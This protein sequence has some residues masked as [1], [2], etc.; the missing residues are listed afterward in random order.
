M[1]PLLLNAARAFAMVAFAD[2]KLAPAE[3]QRFAHLASRDTTL[4]LAGHAE[5]TD[6]WT[7]AAKEVHEAES[8]GAALVTIRSEITA[9]ADKVVLMRVAQTA[10]VA[11]GKVELQENKA[12]A[13]LAEALGLDP[14]NY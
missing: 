12:I 7:Q 4:G 14:E 5:I 2:G 8:F 11:D 3:A 1:T 6:A 10:I 9:K 13:M